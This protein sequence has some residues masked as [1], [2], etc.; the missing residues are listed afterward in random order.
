MLKS[1]PIKVLLVDDSSVMRELLRTIIRSDFFV[2]VGEAADGQ[3]AIELADSL[4]P[5]LVCLDIEMPEKSGIETLKEIKAKYAKTAVVMITGS[6]AAS[7]VQ[8]SL[9]NGADGYILK[10]FNAG[11]VL[12]ALEKAVVKVKSTAGKNNS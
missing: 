12:D 11:R 7:D 2:V 8:Q 4:K 1:Q 5:D 9:S 10:P 3:K 6:N